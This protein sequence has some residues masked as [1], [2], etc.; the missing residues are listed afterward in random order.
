MTPAPRFA[1]HVMVKIRKDLSIIFLAL[2]ALLPAT[3]SKAEVPPP[4]L[5]LSW[6]DCGAAGS[7]NKDFACLTNVGNEALVGS[8]VMPEHIV[9]SI[10]FN[11]SWFFHAPALPD[12]WRIGVGECRKAAAQVDA[13]M[14]GLNACEHYWGQA[15]QS[16]YTYFQLG[17][18]SA[19]L[20]VA[21]ATPTDSARLVSAG[22]EL[23]GFRIVISHM[24][25][26]GTDSCGGCRA[27]TDIALTLAD[28][29]G[30]GTSVQITNAAT[31]NAVTWQAGIVPAKPTSWG[32]VKAL[33][34]RW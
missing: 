27:R 21:V 18:V 7:A 2:S 5:N 19:M 26:V 22:T 12:W 30:G 33:Y 23:Y 25:S 4:G 15:A 16:A 28:I 29:S 8:V 6:D 14:N 3:L 11:T 1:R 9:N 32:M 31:R 24:K 17:P 13:A 34:R 10:T 20:N